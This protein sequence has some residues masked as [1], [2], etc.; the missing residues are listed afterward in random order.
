MDI[1]YHYLYEKNL[2][3]FKNNLLEEEQLLKE[4]V[5]PKRNNPKDCDS[6][7]WRDLKVLQAAENGDWVPAEQLL[8]Q[9]SAGGLALLKRYHVEDKG[10]YPAAYARQRCDA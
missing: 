7:Y 5:L 10:P 3:A 8:A 6:I 2:L 1:R 9:M 4:A